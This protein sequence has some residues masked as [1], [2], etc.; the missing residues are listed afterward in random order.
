MVMYVNGVAAAS[1]KVFG[2]GYVHLVLTNAP[3]SNGA[4]AT[5]VYANGVRVASA[6]TAQGFDLSPGLLRFFADNT[7]GPA[8]GE[9]SA[10]A[11]AC[12]LIFDGTLS[13]SEIQQGATS[14]AHCSD[15][16]GVEYR[17]GPYAGATSQ[18]LP[19]LLT[20]GP[21]TVRSLYFR[22]RARCADGKMHSGGV[23]VRREPI[24]GGHF[25]LARDLRAGGFV[26][27]TGRINGTRAR[28]RLSRRE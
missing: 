21:G 2:P 4:Q 23:F 10:G 24:L 11:V 18:R 15:P 14:S 12:I 9:E 5:T 28:G 7:S 8:P 22:W 3:A 1:S 19:I 6:Q 13:A 16:Q 27:V 25:S 26:H 20:A 17:L